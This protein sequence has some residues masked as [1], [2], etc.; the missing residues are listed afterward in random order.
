MKPIGQSLL[1]VVFAALCALTRPD[2]CMANTPIYREGF[3]SAPAGA[4]SVS[5]WLVRPAGFAIEVESGGAPE[6]KQ[7]V[8]LRKT[9]PDVAATFGNFMRRIPAAGYRGNHVVLRAQVKV[10]G[11]MLPTAQMWLRVDRGSGD[12]GLFDNMADRPVH[13]GGWTTIAIE[14]DI[15]ED[16]ET[17]NF[18]V[19]SFGRGVVFVDD[20]SLEVTGPMMPKQAPS[21]PKALDGGSLANV[22]AAAQIVSYVRFFVASDQARAVASWD[23]VM[24]DV[25]GEA[26]GAANA[27]ALARCLQER[28]RQL[29]PTLQVWA[30]SAA[31]APPVEPV[32]VG[33]DPIGV[34]YWKHWGA[35][36]IGA[37]KKGNIYHSSV[38]K[39]ALGDAPGVALHQNLFRVRELPGG[40][41]CRLPVKVYYNA[42]GTVPAGTIDATWS[43]GARNPRL[44]VGNRGTRLAGIAVVWGVFQHFY[45]YFD[46]VDTDW[47]AALGAGLQAAAQDTNA[48][49]YLG[50][51]RELVAKLHD[52]HGYVAPL[53]QQPS[54]R[55]PMALRWAG[56]DLV[57]VGVE[58][59]GAAA[60]VEIGDIVVAIDERSA[61][62]CYRQVLPWISAAT[63]G[64]RRAISA[65][66]LVSEMSTRSPARI[67]LR[68]GDGSTHEV[69][70]ERGGAVPA[71]TT[72]A[73][74]PDPGQEV[75]PGIVY[76]DLCDAGTTELAAVMAKLDS[77]RGIVFDLRGYP[78]M[79]AYEVLEHLISG[80]SQ[81]AQWHVPVVTL[82]DREG[83][84]WFASGRWAMKPAAPRWAC[85]VVF[86]TDGGAISYAESIMG[87]VEHYKLGD[88]VGAVT[89]GTNGNINPF[90]IPG[91]FRISWTGMK[92]LKH[93]GSRHH[94]V[95]IVPT[96]P[97]SPTAQGIAAGRDEVLEKGIDTL[98]RRLNRD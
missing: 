65:R 66:F 3:E 38:V 57:V 34:A 25:L 14:G 19:L 5:G 89:A 64:W 9:D 11:L 91:G 71:D 90:T 92:V 50:S 94:G 16:A 75:G 68:R 70:L 96:V 26:E 17:L 93:D 35:G 13:A 60:G 1:L 27:I 4:D 31:D 73:R 79:A 24:I 23:Q 80:P 77:A 74:R 67:E 39:E 56:D 95:G 84:E 49:E 32:P 21:E 86:L 54:S 28:L 29:A 40:I 55:L 87:I 58:S 18:G 22:A 44:D 36:N 15:D 72:L 41:S 47:N 6:G 83:V 98:R 7:L 2:V 81:S 46:V 69:L 51:L 30:G 63:E 53:T 48:T 33:A 42:E 10:D 45:P 85:P 20:V 8:K 82:P 61:H 97:V 43:T 88:I 76:F 37:A 78:G 12:M 62:E 52:G 59:T